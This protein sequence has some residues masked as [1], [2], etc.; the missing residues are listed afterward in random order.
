MKNFLKAIGQ[1]TQGFLREEEGAQ[2]VEYAL[3]IA[4]VSI[5][6]VVALKALTNNGGGFSS[7][8]TRVTNCLTTT[9]CT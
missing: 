4:V 7:F 9:T 2:V 8:I 1:S 3:I 6:L 5:A